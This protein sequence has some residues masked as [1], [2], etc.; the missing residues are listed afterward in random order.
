MEDVMDAVVV[1]QPPRVATA[2]GWEH[3]DAAVGA[4]S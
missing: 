3:V 4:A 2:L 1:T